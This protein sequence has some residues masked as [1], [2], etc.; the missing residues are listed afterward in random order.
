M[1][2]KEQ[3][4]Q[5]APGH[6]DERDLADLRDLL[7][8]IDA[9]DT[10]W[11]PPPA[12]LWEKI[13]AEAGVDRSEPG[14]DP[15]APEATEPQVPASVV[16]FRRRRPPLVWMAAAAVVLVVLVGGLVVARTASGPDEV[17]VAAT[18]LDPLSATGSGAARL[19]ET[20]G[21]LQLHVSTDDLD[22]GDGFLELWVIDPEVSRLISLGPLRD[23]GVYDLPA[24][25]E[26]TEYPIVDVSVE[27]FDGDPTHSGDSVLRGTLEV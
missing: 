7:T 11:E 20:D 22:A 9:Q 8:G 3:D 5:P 17:E 15:A 4:P 27:P 24:G 21:A 10:T 13:A 23:D 18:V 19:V 2:D 25:F 14:G 12:G 16:P 26:P 6:D 1:S